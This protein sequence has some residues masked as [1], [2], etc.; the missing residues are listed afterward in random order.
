L[1]SGKNSTIE[2]N[3]QELKKEHKIEMIKQSKK[4]GSLNKTTKNLNIENSKLTREIKT[5]SENKIKK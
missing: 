5:K 2:N 3:I 4:L 1:N